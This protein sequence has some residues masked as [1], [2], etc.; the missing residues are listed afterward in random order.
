MDLRCNYSYPAKIGN[1]VIEIES[2]TWFA[3]GEITA[4][5]NLIVDQ[6]YTGRVEY[7]NG[8]TVAIRDVRETDSAIYKMRFRTNHQDGRYTGLPGVNLSVSDNIFNFNL[9]G[10]SGLS[11][12]IHLFSTMSSCIQP[13]SCK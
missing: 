8:C 12:C 9:N 10:L 5:V 2:L 13:S 6:D 4:P 3:K 11:D 1:T 7:K